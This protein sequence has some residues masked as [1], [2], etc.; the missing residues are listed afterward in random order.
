MVRTYQK[1]GVRGVWTAEA[2][3]R[4]VDAVKRGEPLKTV[5][6]AYHVPRNTLRRHSGA[7]APAKVKKRL[8]RKTVL[9]EPQESKLHDVILDFENSL[10]GLTRNDIQDLVFQFCCKNHIP[11]PFQTHE[12]AGREWLK[13]FIQRHPDISVRKPENVS[14]GRAYGFSQHKVNDFFKKYFSVIYDE[15]GNRVI[16]NSNIYNADESGFT[17]VHRP[18]KILGRKGKR[19]I[20]VLT[21]A[22]KGK[23]ITFL[24]AVSAVGHYVPPLFVFPRKRMKAELL[25]DAPDGSIGAVNLT[26]WINTE[27]FE[28]WFDHFVH[29][30]QPKARPHPTL[31]IFDGQKAHTKNMSL[32]D[33]AKTNNVIMLSLP[34]HCT[35][36]MQPLDR[37]FF[38]SLKNNYNHEVHVWMREHRGVALA[39]I[40]IPALIKLAYNKS[41][42]MENAINGFRV[43][44]LVLPKADI[45]TDEDF[46]ASDNFLRQ[47]A[48]EAD[49]ADENSPVANEITDEIR[50]RPSIVT[51][52]TETDRA[53]DPEPG[54]SSSTNPGRGLD[55]EPGP[56]SSTAPGRGLDPEPG[57]SSSTN[58]G[59]GLDPEPGP[60]SSTAPG[61]G[62]DP[63]PGHSSSTNPGRGLDPEPGHSSST[64]PG[65]G[66]D[67]EPG[68]SSSTTPGRGLDPEPGHSSST[69]PGRGPDPEPCP[70][71]STNPGRG[72]DP[73]PG[74]SS[75][76]NPDRGPDPEPCPS[77]STNPGRGP[78]PEPGPSSS[79]NTN[80]S[81]DTRISGAQDMAFEVILNRISPPAATNK[82]K[83]KR[84]TESAEIITSSPYKRRLMAAQKE[85]KEKEVKKGLNK[86]SKSS[87]TRKGKRN[88]M[89]AKKPGP[90]GR[91]QANQTAKKCKDG[92]QN[93]FVNFYCIYCTE[94]YVDPPD[95]PWI[96][97]NECKQ[98]AHENETDYEGFG[99]FICDECR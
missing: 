54:P 45:F 34:P 16:P 15:D 30:V 38:K 68:H 69:N 43:S 53:P 93:C 65:R 46:Q 37:T 5:A 23:T 74:H 86:N 8:G 19:A 7:N 20:A 26:G 52:G 62:L 31:L 83:R 77:S 2:M 3:Q 49:L 70:S 82:K 71:S 63:E 6:R 99:G 98:W 76:T 96:Q 14:I 18:E 61:R 44:G 85:Q 4:A 64:A 50:Q 89:Q 47:Q 58:P 48:I 39:Q 66:L 17:I 36:K 91:K 56:S 57:H 81:E 9:S 40:K 95:F 1:K 90:S 51:T 32:I 24:P 22:E 55:P 67:P 10:Y 94:L 21:S 25:E 75:S 97:C 42:N 78:D 60:S 72:L 35:H 87:S 29:V 27:I 13:G 11:N 80:V 84:K 41:A 79:T 59:R 12:R 88:N 33:K 28:Q 73:E 92:P